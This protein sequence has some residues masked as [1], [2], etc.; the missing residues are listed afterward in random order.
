MQ[1]SPLY[2]STSQISRLIGKLLQTSDTPTPALDRLKSLSNSFSHSFSVFEAEQSASNVAASTWSV[3]KTYLFGLVMI[4]TAL[5]QTSQSASPNERDLECL[6][7]LQK[8]HFIA[9]EFGPEGFPSY[10]HL[11]NAF[12]NN[13]DFLAHLSSG[14]VSGNSVEKSE[15]FFRWSSARRVAKQLTPFQVDELLSELRPFVLF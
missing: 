2:K 15:A 12:S 13:A 7:M 10:A 14:N 11:L 5:T 3:L 6:A 8:V 9:L 1:A 4:L